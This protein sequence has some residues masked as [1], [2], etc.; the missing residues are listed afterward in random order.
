MEL[1][2]EAGN[3][4]QCPLGGPCTSAGDP[5]H[6]SL[7]SW[8]YFPSSFFITV[9]AAATSFLP[10]GRHVSPVFFLL[11]FLSELQKTERVLQLLA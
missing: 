9:A 6:P 3:V 2:E 10:F 4:A 8:L 1:I 5:D 11:D 7:Y